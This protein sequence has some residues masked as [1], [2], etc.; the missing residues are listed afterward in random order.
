MKIN[1]IELQSFKR[2]SLNNINSFK[3]TPTARVQL[4][5]GTNGSGKSSLISELS[6]LPASQNNYDKDGYKTISITH[7]GNEYTLS[8]KFS[9]TQKHS[10]IKN[11]TEELN[12]GGT[13]TVQKDL[14]KDIFGYRQDI[15]DLLTGVE[16]F[17]LMSPAL[18]RKW[19]TELCETN[20]DYAINVYNR[21]AE[22]S[23]DTSGALK[24]ARKRLVVETSK[25]I[26]SEE[27]EKIQKSIDCILREIDL[28]YNSRTESINSVS[29]ITINRDNLETEIL[30]H[31]DRV[32]LLSKIKTNGESKQPVDLIEDI[33]A[34]KHNITK[35]KT[36]IDV[37][38]KSYNELK[39]KYDAYSKNTSVGLE[40]LRKSY[41]ELTVRKKELQDS[42][43]LNLTFED[44]I[45]AKAALTSVYNLLENLLH[46]LPSN[47]EKTLSYEILNVSREKEFELKDKIKKAQTSLEQ[48]SHQK[49]HMEQLKNGEPTEC[50]QCRHRWV[51]GYS[52]SAL[53]KINYSIDQGNMFLERSEKELNDIKKTIDSN[54]SYGELMR[55][56]NRCVK[57]LPVLNPFWNHIKETVYS[58]PM[59][60]YREME[61][62]MLDLEYDVKCSNI[63]AEKVKQN[64]LIELA[65]K[66][67]DADIDKIGIMLKT[68]ETELGVLTKSI[69]TNQNLLQQKQQE[70][71]RIQEILDLSQEITD[72]I[73]DLNKNTVDLIKSLKNEFINKCLNQLQ[74][75]L[76]SKQNTLNEA[77][78]QRGIVTD[79]ENNISRLEMEEEALKI[80]VTSLSPH[81]G[82]IAEGLLGFIRSFVR[83]MNLLIKKIWTYKLEVQDCSVDTNVDN[84]ELDYKFPIIVGD[85]DN[86][87]SDISKGSSGM[88]EIV[89]L[90]FK[91]VAMQ[92]LNMTTAPLFADELGHAMDV[93]HKACTVNLIKYL[94]EHC[95]FSQFYMISHDYSQFTALSNAECCVLSESNIVTPEKYNEHVE[96][97]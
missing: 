65:I 97:S 60:A 44:P 9:P 80:I 13:V 77:N 84:A 22:R 79:I 66:A 87:V 31:S 47:S 92:Y 7:M 23:R 86:L 76:A 11:G 89:D 8:S 51:L 58:S 41:S 45:T 14:V 64:S 26:S 43:Q 34:I 67:N 33:D 42:K 4:I 49:K 35:L 40:E 68:V 17:S 83:K 6:P 70:L 37:N 82:L 93:E 81:D 52:I 95:S 5:L 78:L 69:R 94:L 56:Y 55:E 36:Q 20:Y 63:E 25:I 32:L 59:Q 73:N 74:I 1:W 10:I 53:T 72:K 50:P 21:A 91:I 3:M 19:F 46:Q 18:R 15:H 2:M 96:M 71:I 57:T 88:C 62:L 39:D 27:I 24:L 85:N 12:T 54:V 28:L 30:K 61:R 29:E 75:Q 38:T 16:K 48:L 90:S